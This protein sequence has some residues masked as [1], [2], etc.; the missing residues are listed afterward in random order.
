MEVQ[1][2][3]DQLIDIH[4]NSFKAMSTMGEALT[5]RGEESMLLYL[6]QQDEPVLSGDLT[7][8][9]G[10]TSGRV[11]NILRVLEAKQLI[12]RSQGIVDKRQVQVCLTDGGRKVA[13][14]CYRKM[15]GEYREMLEFLGD[16]AE[17]A[18]RLIRK[19][20]KYYYIRGNEAKS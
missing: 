19:L 3:T 7:V 14:T 2:L 16:D 20:V 10:L 1:K 17:E 9:L 15:I 11:A 8:H 5:T 18:T 12:T 6:Y 4:L 13:E